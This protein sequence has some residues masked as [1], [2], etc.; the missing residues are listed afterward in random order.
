MPL[1]SRWPRA[2]L[3]CVV[4]LLPAPWQGAFAQSYPTRPIRLVVPYPP[5]GIDVFARVMLPK[6]SELLGQP[7]VIDN[8]AGANGIIGSDNVVHSPPDGHSLLFVTA[9]TIVVVPVLTKVQP[10]DTV[11]DFTPIVNLLDPL[12]ILTVHA[13]LPVASVKELIDYAKR[14][15]GKLSYA[16]S[17][18]GSVFYLNG[19]QLKLLAGMDIVHVPYKGSAPM[20]TDL[21]AGR[22]EVGL[23]ALNNVN[24]YLGSGK[25]RILAVLDSQRYAG[26]P[27][28]PTLAETVAGFRKTPTWTAVFGPASLPRPIV[29]RLNGVFLKALDA[30]EVRK[31]IDERGAVIRG[32]TPQD[33]A[34]TI[35]SDLEL[36]EKLIKTIGIQPE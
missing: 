27:G 33:L 22:I 19:E 21:L 2:G 26:L 13:S 32:G 31:F 11:K 8:R 36:T 30:P 6:A 25:L 18:V 28:V 7:V 23:P 4:L 29:E 12:Q 1:L 14:N 34:A 16:S 35:R 10:F 20:T 17:G 5:G 24:E 3:L 9:G 15:P